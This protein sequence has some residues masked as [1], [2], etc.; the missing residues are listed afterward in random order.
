MNHSDQFTAFVTS[1]IVS[2][3]EPY[4][5]APDLPTNLEH[6]PGLEAVGG[7]CII[8]WLNS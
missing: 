7:Y 4:Q 6:D 3:D 5:T 8:S 1:V 2:D